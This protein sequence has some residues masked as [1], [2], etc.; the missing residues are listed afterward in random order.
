MPN[1]CVVY[2]CKTACE[3][4]KEKYVSTF[5]FPLASSDKSFLLEHWIRFVNRTDW[6]PSN[7][8]V[9]CEKHF[10]SKFIITGKQR[11]CLDWKLNPTPTIYT[12]KAL[13]RPSNLP[14][15]TMP[16]K[17]PKVRIYQED[18]LSNFINMYTINSFE[19]L[20]EKNCLPNFNRMVT[21]DAIVY[22]NVV[23]N[24]NLM[25]KIVE[26][27]KVSKDMR[28]ELQYMGNPVPLPP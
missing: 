1:K 9:I 10:E 23:F 26:S 3:A 5:S 12:D 14:V 19:E 21:P 4:C 7:N 18:Q 20:C 27:I 17:S 25:P 28:V 22:Y 16:R 8:S 2:G 11:N 13:K 6:K 24:D 15:L